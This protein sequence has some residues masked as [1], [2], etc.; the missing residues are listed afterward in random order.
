MGG[1]SGA[2]TGGAGGAGTGYP[3]GAGT[4]GACRSGTVGSGA[5]GGGGAGTSG[6]GGA[7]ASD[8]AESGG[9]VGW[10][11]RLR[12]SR[13]VAATGTSSSGSGGT[14]RS[15]LSGRTGRADTS[16]MAARVGTVRA[17][18]APLRD[19]GTRGMAF[20]TDLAPLR[21]RRVPKNGCVADIDRVVAVAMGRRA[22]GG[23]RD[24]VSGVNT[25]K[26][27]IGRGSSRYA[28]GQ[29][30]PKKIVGSS[31]GFSLH[32]RLF[33][34]FLFP[35]ALCSGDGSNSGR[36]SSGPSGFKCPVCSKSVASN[37]MEVH[38]IMCLSKPRLSYNDDV[39]ARDAGEC[40]ICLEE[41][42]QGDTIA[43]LPCLCIYHKSC[44]D[45]W[46]EINRSC[47]EHPS[48]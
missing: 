46:F 13:G 31:S 37:E 8:R 16:I 21:A 11:R 19:H 6:G 30:A 38:F 20:H 1:A 29:T 43:R 48:D 47:P 17:G 27:R 18:T 7:G 5:S 12:T 2:G 15:G 24:V 45:S 34:F 39:L 35:P 44:I 14:G 40:V 28:A 23:C 26:F 36:S 42:Q 33:R 3:A 4:A 9:S 22:S 25:A 10:R 41:L 32:L